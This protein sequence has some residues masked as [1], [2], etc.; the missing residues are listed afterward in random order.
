MFRVLFI[1][2]ENGQ[3]LEAG[4]EMND[5]SSISLISCISPSVFTLA[6]KTLYY[7]YYIVLNLLAKAEWWSLL[8][9]ALPGLT[10]E[11]FV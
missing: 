10:V 11:L 4:P 2:C 9:T 3:G 8:Y 5:I 7:N 6:R 1:Q